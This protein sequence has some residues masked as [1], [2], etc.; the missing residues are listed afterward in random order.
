MAAHTRV[1]IDCDPGA[2]AGPPLSPR[3]R[4]VL[5]SL[6]RGE[7][8]HAIAVRLG[9]GERTVKTHLTQLYNKLGVNSRAEAVDIARQRGWLATA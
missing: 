6:A 2:P 9:I 5:E 8:N 7:S 4:D 3:E 1:R